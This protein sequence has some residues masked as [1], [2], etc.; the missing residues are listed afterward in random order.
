MIDAFWNNAGD[1]Y[2]LLMSVQPIIEHVGLTSVKVTKGKGTHVTTAATKQQPIWITSLIQLARLTTSMFDCI[3]LV[4]E[5][6][7]MSL[8]ASCTIVSPDCLLS[9]D[10]IS[11]LG[12]PPASR[13]PAMCPDCLSTLQL[14]EYCTLV[15]SMDSCEISVRTGITSSK[16]CTST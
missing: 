5:R 13:F 1:K 9:S 14:A 7:S 10:P 4:S 16:F 8:V 6:L 12:G 3:C 11:S 15:G 2:N